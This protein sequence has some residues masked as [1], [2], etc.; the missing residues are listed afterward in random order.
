MKILFVCTGNI[1]RSPYAEALARSLSEDN[2][3]AFASAGTHAV[4]GNGA[5]AT[6]VVAAA[7]R[8]LDLS[9]HLATYLTAE[10]LTAYDVT[11]GMSPEHVNAVLSL[12]PSANVSLLRSDGEEV[13]DPYGQDISE[14][15]AVFELIEQALELRMGQLR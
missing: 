8:G 2:G 9:A 15:Q 3:M 4:V 7:E 6:G 12:D 14:Y 11:Y 5:S 10:L 13:P 1:C